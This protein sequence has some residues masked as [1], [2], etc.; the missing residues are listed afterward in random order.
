MIGGPAL[1][2]LTVVCLLDKVRHSTVSNYT[3]PDVCGRQTVECGVRSRKPK[4]VFLARLPL[5]ERHPRHFENT[6]SGG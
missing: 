4:D 1:R 3:P 5:S 2:R 6:I